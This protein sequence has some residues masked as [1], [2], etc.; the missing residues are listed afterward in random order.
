MERENLFRIDLDKEEMMIDREEFILRRESAAVRAERMELG[1]KL[2][3]SIMKSVLGF[4]GF[5]TI[6]FTF[7]L[8]AG[9]CCAAI[10]LFGYLETKVFSALPLGLT[11]FFLLLSGVLGVLKK[12]LDRKHEGEDPAYMTDGEY[13]R[14]NQ[15]SER[16]LKI[17]DGAKTVE[18]FGHFYHKDSESDGPYDV[19]QMAIFEEDGMLCLHHVGAVIAVPIDS[20]EAVVKMEDTVTF[21]D[22]MKDVP[23]DSEPYAQYHIKKRQVSEYEEEYSMDGY[24]SIRFSKEDTPFEL[25]VPLYEI[26][27]FLEILKPRVTEERR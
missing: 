13:D 16:E 26:E 9:I 20:I 3:K 6:S 14:L 1:E 19:D 22:W 15:I 10:T 11:V 12:V 7:S 23:H 2:T 17:P 8:M 4:G 25:V 18:L 21:S 24:Y 5:L 27:P